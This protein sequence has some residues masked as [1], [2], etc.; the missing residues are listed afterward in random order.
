MRKIFLLFLTVSSFLIAQSENQIGWI[1]K[2]GAAGGIT[3][4]IILPNYDGINSELTNIGMSKLSGPIVAWGGGGYA[5]VMIID[6]LRLGGIGFS[7]YK[8]ESTVI[9]NLDTETKYSIGGGA[10]TIEYTFPFV[11]NMALSA[12]FMFGGGSLDID[13]YQNEGS[14][15]WNTIWDD[16]KNGNSVDYKELSIKNSYYF[17]LPTVNIDFPITRFLAIRG[18]IGY[19]FTFGDDWKIGN[20]KNLNSV[21]S[22]IN[23]NGLVFQTGILIGL[24]AF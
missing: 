19:Q 8:S 14:F 22:N 7:G 18:G 12:G 17:V 9:K 6:N 1:A 16:I 2:F 21:P 10:L 23:A 13:V 5:Y 4:M 3:P 11:K 20:G 15:N 24:F